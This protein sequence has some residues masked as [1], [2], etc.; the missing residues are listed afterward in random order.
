VGL[1]FIGPNDLHLALGLPPRFWSD[2][3]A[4]LSAVARV[5]A[6]ARERGLPLGTLCR[7]AEAAR[8]RMAEG[9][10]FVGVGSDAHFLLT[11]CGEE[12]GALRGI[13]EPAA[14]CDRVR[15]D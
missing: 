7:D 8:A 12:L 3:P 15:F 10:R 2:E 1:C 4:F 6:A 5:R 13:P 14:W 9:F 11:S